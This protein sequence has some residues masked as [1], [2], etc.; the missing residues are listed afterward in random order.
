MLGRI[1][2]FGW[3]ETSFDL[4]SDINSPSDLRTYV[5]DYGNHRIVYFDGNLNFL[6]FLQLHEGDDLANKF[7]YPRSVATDRFGALYVV[8]GENTRVVKIGESNSIEL[9]F[10]GMDGG[11]GRLSM[12]GRLR[13][14]PDDI[15]Y[16]RDGGRILVYDIYG[17]YI[18]IVPF[19]DSS[20]FRTFTV[21]E[22][23]LFILDSLG[24]RGITG[25]VDTTIAVDGFEHAIDIAVSNNNMYFLTPTGIIVQPL[26]PVWLKQSGN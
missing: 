11:K 12:P 20:R 15:A 1:G 6:S 5:A 26:D 23:S 16:V 4:P 9:T 25:G 19:A 21:Y 8:D 3:S 18:R 10:G 24:V 13:I 7:G 14:S 17:N 2:G 22:S